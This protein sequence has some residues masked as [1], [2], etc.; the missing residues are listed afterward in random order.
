MQ[1]V[2]GVRAR[3]KPN[4]NKNI[5]TNSTENRV[6]IAN[7]KNPKKKQKKTKRKQRIDIYFCLLLRNEIANAS[8]HEIA[9]PQPTL[10]V[11]P[12]PR[13]RI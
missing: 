7:K 10:A 11:S 2:P 1:T 3:V 4:N 9:Q 6:T 5:L 12:K 13:N 8:K